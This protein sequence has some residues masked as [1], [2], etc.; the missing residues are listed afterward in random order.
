MI[1]LAPG[2]LE[3]AP[4]CVDGDPTIVVPAD[5]PHE[6]RNADE[7]LVFVAVYAAASVVTRYEQDVQ[8][9]GRRER[10]TVD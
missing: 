10:Q 7:E 5:A 6:V 2:E 4:S 8:P 1:A 3:F 9:D